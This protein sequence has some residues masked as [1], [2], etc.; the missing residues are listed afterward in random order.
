MSPHHVAVRI[1]STAAQRLQQLISTERLRE[2]C[3]LRCLGQ[4]ISVTANGY[5]Y[6]ENVD[7]TDGG[8]AGVQLRVKSQAD[9]TVELHA[10]S[11]TGALLGTC[12]VP[13]TRVGTGKDVLVEAVWGGR[14]DGAPGFPARRVRVSLSRSRARSSWQNV[15]AQSGARRPARCSLLRGGFRGLGLSPP[16]RHFLPRSLQHPLALFAGHADHLGLR[17]LD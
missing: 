11:Q 5:V 4:S 3:R 7:Y 2:K 6:F 8:V 12:A 10:D 17:K 9:A 1:S 15:A 16:D 14:L 13:S